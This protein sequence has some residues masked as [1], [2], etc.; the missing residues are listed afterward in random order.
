MAGHKLSYD[1]VYNNSSILSGRSKQGEHKNLAHSAEI[2]WY[3]VSFY[4]NKQ[5]QY[6]WETHK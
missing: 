5:Q 3:K 2:Y 6:G 4:I 1:G